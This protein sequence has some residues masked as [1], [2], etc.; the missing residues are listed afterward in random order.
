MTTATYLLPTGAARFTLRRRYG[1]IVVTEDGTGIV[2]V[3]ADRARAE[4]V[5]RRR[6]GWPGRYFL[7]DRDTGT[8][9]EIR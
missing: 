6:A 4:A 1:L 7:L 9:E 2:K 8:V 5:G 3:T